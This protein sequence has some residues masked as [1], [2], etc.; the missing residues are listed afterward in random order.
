MVL[1]LPIASASHAQTEEW[2]HQFGTSSTDNAYDIAVSGTGDVYVAGSTLGAFYDQVSIGDRDAFVRKYNNAG[3]VIWT[4]QFGTTKEDV[5]NGVTVDSVGNIYVVG[6]TRGSL[7]NQISAGSTDA[8]VRKYDSAGGEMWTI[9][10]GTSVS[11]SATGVG[12]DG[13]GNIYVVGNRGGLSGFIHKYDN[14]GIEI[15]TRQFDSSADVYTGRVAVDDAGNAYIAGS[16]NGTFAGQASAGYYDAFISKYDSSG[17][18]AWIRQF[19]TSSYDDAS[20]AIDGL[21][22]VY[23]AGFAGEALPGQVSKG[24]GDAFI[25]KY[26]NTGT[27]VWTRQF[28]S[29]SIDAAQNVAVGGEGSVYVVGSTQG[30]LPGQTSAGSA[31]SFVRKYAS[32]GNDIWTH[33]FG[34][35]A[36]DVAFSI[37]ANGEK[38]VYLAG[39]TSGTL[40]T[41]TSEGGQDAFV[42]KY[43]NPTPSDTIPPSVITNLTVTETTIDSVTLSWTA[44]G[45][46]GNVGIATTYDIRYSTSPIT[47]FNW[48]S[49]TKAV[50]EPIPKPAGSEESFEVTGLTPGSFYY[51][52]MKTSDEVPDWSGLSNIVK[53]IPF[54]VYKAQEPDGRTVPEASFWGF[55]STKNKEDFR[56]SFD[57]QDE[58]DPINVIFFQQDPSPTS[59]LLRVF[60]ALINNGWTTVNPCRPLEADIFAYFDGATA[61]EQQ[62]LSLFKPEKGCGEKFHL[63]L[64]QPEAFSPWVIGAAHHECNNTFLSPDD[65]RC[66]LFD[67][68]IGWEDAE[69]KMLET[70]QNSGR[71]VESWMARLD[72]TDFSVLHGGL[73]RFNL[74]NLLSMRNDGIAEVFKLASLSDGDTDGITNEIDTRPTDFS[75][76]FSDGITNGSIIDRGDQTLVIV[77]APLLDDG[78]LIY[79]DPAGGARIAIVKACGSNNF[80]ILRAGTVA[81]ITCGSATIEVINGTVEAEFFADSGTV[82]TTTLD[83]GNSLIFDPETITFTAPSTNISTVII[84]V[85]EEE[86][87]LNPGETVMVNQAPTADAGQD[88]TIEATSPDG[89]EATLDGISSSDPNGDTLTY[90]WSAHGV[91]FDDPTSPTPTATFPLGTTTVTLVVNDGTVDSEPDI[92]TITVEDTTPP[93]LTATANPSSIWPPNGKYQLITLVITASDVRDPSPT[94][95]AVVQ[96]NEPDDAKGNGDGNTTGDIKVTTS[97]GPA[98]LSSNGFPQVAFDPINGQLELRAERAGGGTGRQY[99]IE[100]TATDASGNQT[101]KTLIVTVPHDQRKIP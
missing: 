88:Q 74:A 44:P 59:A 31:D 80:R 97:G 16:T 79:T 23:V 73:W 75:N 6:W 47:D 66:G 12:V 13:A 91:T 41:Q 53:A 96:S 67:T 10:F 19:G 70:M 21:G 48:D 81:R 11:D 36:D 82:A 38:N 18:N 60:I 101:T 71:V 28:G 49:V 54:W 1:F 69:D 3:N 46:D 65:D 35:A 86:F 34:S 37:T 33:Q 30:A 95:T 43:S 61:G 87:F 78:V 83:V 45:D 72:N 32:T 63:R 93:T 26:D 51:F 55:V 56:F 25:R 5:A 92:V 68:V 24:S 64:F 98:L 20:V 8:F 15:W 27:E 99:T 85:E 90:S 9:Q 89:A 57:R 58:L 22:Y 17:N 40:P 76:D 94:V 7:P 50:G 42:S 14:T 52:A 4:R 77:D 62:I 29:S 2:T 84:L 39:H 100:I